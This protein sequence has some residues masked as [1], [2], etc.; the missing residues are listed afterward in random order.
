VRGLA[1]ANARFT[2]SAKEHC[3]SDGHPSVLVSV[4]ERTGTAVVRILGELDYS[5]SDQLEAAI[6]STQ[7]ASPQ[8]VAIDFTECRYID[9]TVLTVLIR[10]SKTLGEGLRVVIP[11]DSHIRRIFAI[12]NLDRM[13]QIDE[14]LE[15]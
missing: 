13:M 6:D 8:S 9:S 10:A 15:T 11:H 2:T 4:E 3:I 12:T 7:S 14:R 5:S 1:S